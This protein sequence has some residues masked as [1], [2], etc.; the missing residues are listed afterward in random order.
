MV[1][2]WPQYFASAC[3]L[4]Y[5]INLEAT[6]QLAAAVMELHGVVEHPD[7]QVRMFSPLWSL[8]ESLWSSLAHP[9]HV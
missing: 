3:C 9:P 8:A 5:V 1:P 2:V 6:G 7:M 4:L